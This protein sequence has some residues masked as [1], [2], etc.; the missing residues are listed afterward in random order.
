MTAG[1]LRGALGGVGGVLCYELFAR[2]LASLA[3][4]VKMIA[5]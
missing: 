2:L 4:R 1:L 5:N 3:Y